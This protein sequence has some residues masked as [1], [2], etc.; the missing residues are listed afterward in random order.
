M[1]VQAASKITGVRRACAAIGWSRSHYYRLQKP[2][3]VAARLVLP[4]SKP[5]HSNALTS[6]EEHAVIAL[7]NSARFLDCAPREV[8]ATLLG[9]GT[10][11][12]SWRTMYRLLSKN[13]PVQERRKIR[14][15][16]KYARPELEATGPNQVWTWDITYLKGPIRGQFNYLYVAMDI[17][18]RL[19]VGW[20]IANEESAILAEQ[21]F[22]KSLKKQAVQ[23]GQLTLHADR[24]APMKNQT[25][26]SFL[27]RMQVGISHSRPRVSNDNCF[28]EAGFKTMKYSADFPARFE[29]M[30]AAELFCRGYFD[31]YNNQHHHSGV[32][33]MTPAQV[34]YGEADKVT[35]KRLDVME[36]VFILHPER[37]RKGHPAVPVLPTRVWINKPA[38]LLEKVAA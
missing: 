10:Y 14:R 32:A 17:F 9:E 37:F 3:V 34:H 13:A 26:E 19:V 12:C 35:A 4:V 21:L 1:M 30:E 38:E 15:H 24:G 23:R 31:W 33:F 6:D 5:R 18:S 22:E 8:W 27:T 28:S 29:S 36:K 25:M 20:L 11:H 2:V 16:P 7:L